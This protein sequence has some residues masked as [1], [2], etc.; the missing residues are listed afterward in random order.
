[1]T[2]PVNDP[3][4]AALLARLRPELAEAPSLPPLREDPN[5]V[6]AGE[7]KRA[8]VDAVAAANADPG[9]TDVYRAAAISRAWTVCVQQLGELRTDLDARRTA[10]Q[11]SIGR[12]LPLGPGIDPAASPADRVVLMA[13]FSGA[14]E[15][16][17]AASEQD[18]AEQL[19]TAERFGDDAGRRGALTALLDDAMWK[20]V[21]RWA[22]AHNPTAAGLFTE[23]KALGE[24]ILGY[25]GNV[26]TR[27][28]TMQFAAP[29]KPAEVDA[30][31]RLVTA[32][33]NNVRRLNGATEVRNGTR[34]GGG[35]VLDVA[36]LLA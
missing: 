13:A 12:L 32:H 31:P 36:Q 11:E 4:F 3:G 9:L 23:F 18:R 34:P 25:T 20:S 6:R 15:K 26:D 16:A 28:E 35:T 22:E 10:R 17:K 24:L 30:L 14:Y 5:F 8:Y 21:N 19:E 7:V 2:S 33:N 1:M 27:F 29:P